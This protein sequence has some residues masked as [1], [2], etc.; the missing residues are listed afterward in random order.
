MMIS[1]EQKL[2]TQLQNL[3]KIRPFKPQIEDFIRIVPLYDLVAVLHYKAHIEDYSEMSL[4][5]VARILE[6]HSIEILEPYHENNLIRR[7]IT[8]AIEIYKELFEDDKKASWQA[9]SGNGIQFS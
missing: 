7:L 8:S 1:P 4:Y 5:H 2:L 9:D 6:D 3:Q